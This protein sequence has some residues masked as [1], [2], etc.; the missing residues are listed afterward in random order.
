VILRRIV[1]VLVIVLAG[2]QLIRLAKT[3]PP[4]DPRRTLHA[5]LSVDAPI[6]AIFERSC[7]DCHTHETVWPW[8][9]NVAPISWMVIHDVN[10]GRGK[11]DLSEWAGYDAAEQHTLLEHMCR[12]VS[13]G[14]MPIF[15]YK[16]IH[17]RA[18]LSDADKKAI[19]DWT[20]HVA[21]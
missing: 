10:E 2:A 4:I 21:R 14:D 11:M 16:I 17:T 13:S 9:S 7:K 5:S 3:N 1:L 19:C 15:A 12:E 8:Y 6:A 18:V 20:K